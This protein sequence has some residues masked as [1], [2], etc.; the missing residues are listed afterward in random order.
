MNP[1]KLPNY[2]N[3]SWRQGA[4]EGTPLYDPVSGDL[5]ARAD[6]SGLDLGAALQYARSEGTSALQQMTYAQRAVLLEKAA[7]VLSAQKENYYR[8]S[9]ENSGNTAVDAMID[10][11]GGIGT[12]KYFAALGKSMGDTHF[13]AEP[14]LDRL[15]KDKTFQAAHILTPVKGVAIHINAFNFP[16]WG[17]WEKAAVALLSGVACFVKPATATSL[18]TYQ[19]V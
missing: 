18:L 16:S 2:L 11:D 1:L 17:L 7:E 6:S 13:L 5:L 4:G 9:L 12:L 19:M 3:G 8:I 15:A 10:V 14:S